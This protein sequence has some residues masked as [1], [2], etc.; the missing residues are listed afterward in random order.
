M[1][2]G[3][4]CW[5]AMGKSSTGAGPPYTHTIGPTT[6]GTP[7]P[8][9]TINHEQKGSAT[10]EE[11]QFMGCKIDSL[12]MI[13]D[14]KDAPFLMGKVEVRGLGAQDGI[15]LTNDPSLPATANTDAYVELE[16]K[17]DTGGAH[18]GPLDIDGLQ[19]VEI[20]IANGLNPLYGRTYDTGTYTGM[21]PYQLLESSRKEYKIIMNL[22][23]NTIE[24]D[25]W[26][27]LISTTT[28][29]TSTFKWIRSANDY[30]L[31]TAVGPVVDHQLITPKVGDTL[32]EQVVIEPY[33]LNIEVKDSIAGA[34]NYGE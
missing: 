22:H 34:T 20:H 5:M 2:N 27:S 4:L 30:I 10:N 31:V 13:Y 26:D 3:I 11:Y 1:Q 23:P 9:F 24:R 15:A 7:L 25:M 21:W 12:A 14:M 8:S 17:W 32:I 33:D 28:A 18:G 29:I 16:R 6:D 19:R